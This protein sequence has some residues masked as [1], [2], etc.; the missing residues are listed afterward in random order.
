MPA[1]DQDEHEEA[2]LFYVRATRAT[3]RLIVGVSGG[4][5]IWA[6]LYPGT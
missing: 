6:R 3:Q 5:D 2:R 1:P 4:G